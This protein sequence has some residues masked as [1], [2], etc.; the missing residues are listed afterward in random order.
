MPKVRMLSLF[1]AGLALVGLIVAGC[2]STNG[3]GGLYG[4]NGNTPAATNT[5]TAGGGAAAS[6]HTAT[7]TVQGKSVTALTDASG[8]TLYYFTPDSASSSACTGSC[9]SAWPPLLSPGGT[10][11][12]T[13]NLPGTL[14]VISDANGMQVVYN[15]HPL[16]TFSGD[17]GPDMTN[18]EGVLGKWFVATTDLPVQSSGGGGSATPTTP[19]GY[20]YH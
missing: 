20:Y 17:T 8:K 1:I 13:A 4:S 6:V 10:P 11:A 12:N 3:G 18:G 2:G 7:E 16:Y 15:G 14:G 19:G 5:T 9:A